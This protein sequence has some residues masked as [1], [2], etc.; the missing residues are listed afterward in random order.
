MC[1]E[2]FI[3]ALLV[4]VTEFVLKWPCKFTE[5]QINISDIL[6]CDRRCTLKSCT[7]LGVVFAVV[8]I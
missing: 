4:L 5:S 2:L 3:V 6:V 8:S 7:R 1:T